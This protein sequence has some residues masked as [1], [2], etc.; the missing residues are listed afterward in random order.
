MRLELAIFSVGY[1]DR[2]ALLTAILLAIL[3]IARPLMSLAI[4]LA[5]VLPFTQIIAALIFDHAPP[6][7]WIRLPL[8]PAFFVLDA[9]TAV[10]AMVA[11]LLNLPRV[12]YKTERV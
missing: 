6:G 2:L 10:W 5:L 11:T 12:W 1:L 7:M 9:A 4:A 8:T 3:G